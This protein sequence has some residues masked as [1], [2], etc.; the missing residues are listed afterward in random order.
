MLTNLLASGAGRTLSAATIMVATVAILAAAP[1]AGARVLPAGWPYRRALKFKPVPLRGAPGPNEAW[2]QF[3]TNKARQPNGNDL[4][5]TNGAR[6]VM[7]MKIIRISPHDDLVRVIFAARGQRP[8]FAWWGNPHAG[9]SKQPPLKI[10]RS[11]FM[12]IFRYPGGAVNSTQAVNNQFARAGRPLDG[13]VIPQIFIGYDPLGSGR[14]DMLRYRALLH[15]TQGGLY[16]FAFDVDDA[17]YVRLNHKTILIKRNGGGMM[18]NVRFKTAVQ[19][20]PGW[21]P[22]TAAQINFAGPT[23]IAFDWRMPGHKRYAPV[24]PP[25]FAPIFHAHAGPLKKF[26]LPYVADFRVQPSAETF[27]PPKFY[28]TRYIFEARV[29]ASFTPRVTWTFGDGQRGQGLRLSHEFLH[30]GIYTVHMTVHQAGHSF[31]ATRRIH[32]PF[33][34]YSLFPHPPRDTAA[35]V[36]KL[37]SE[38]NLKA[39]SGADLRR[40]MLF[41]RG[42]PNAAQRMRWGLAWAAAATP[43]SPQTV[44]HDGR[45]LARFLIVHRHFKAAARAYLLMTHKP[46]PAWL[47]AKVMAAYARTVCYF[48]PQFAG[49][50]AALRTRLHAWMAGVIAHAPAARHT[51]LVAL[52]DVA[53]AAGSGKQ[54]S[55]EIKKAGI[56]GTQQTKWQVIRE[57]VLARNA[58]NYIHYDHTD[59]AA[60]ILDRWENRY[61]PA[62][63]RGY[64]RL[65]RMKLFEKLNHPR[66]AARIAREY[67]RAY[68]RSFYADHLLFRAYHD[69]LAAHQQQQAQA[70]AA[71]LKKDYPESPYA[72]KI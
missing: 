1:C 46:L 41:F 20:K 30:S 35:T 37:L 19:L 15:I 8:F 2:A 27:V 23:G 6:I 3:Y 47:K 4:R 52:A 66:A 72:S 58:E 7:P 9:P 50:A 49:R 51:L 5:I 25:A 62:I 29:P 28:F 17:G 13:L 40:G 36:G 16:H 57:G 33:R 26:G 21:Y 43:Q 65:L 54:A 55:A 59:L 39:L 11:V 68:P 67:V 10:Q 61:P 14:R 32:V 12:N 31:S 53:V 45:Q 64:T 18:G 56:T 70:V 63:A 34:P 22:V 69:L 42:Y 24:P 48:T 71:K 60:H 38:Y 44:W